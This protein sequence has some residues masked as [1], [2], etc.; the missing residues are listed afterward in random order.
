MSYL[1]TKRRLTN[2]DFLYRWRSISQLPGTLR[3]GLFSQMQIGDV[4]Q[5][6]TVRVCRAQVDLVQVAVS[7][8]CVLP[9]QGG[10]LVSRGSL[11]SI[12][13][14]SPAA[15]ATTMR[16]QKTTKFNSIIQRKHHLQ[17]TSPQ[18]TTGFI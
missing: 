14:L 17:T 1:Q 11:V 4:L 12:Y 6:Q 16:T 18:G 10:S 13:R 3:S 9:I 7:G 8:N 15:T 2:T 5:I